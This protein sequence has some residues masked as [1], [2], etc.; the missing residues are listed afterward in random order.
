MKY[1]LPFLFAATLTMSGLISSAV[2]QNPAPTETDNSDG[3]SADVLAPRTKTPASTT[4]TTAKKGPPT[5][6]LA[7]DAKGKTPATTFAPNDKI[8]L[9]WTAPE[10]AKGDKLRAVWIA[11]DTGKA[12]PKNKK[13]IEDNNTVPGPGASGAFVS[14]AVTGGLPAG[15]YL[16]EFYINAKLIKSAKFTVGK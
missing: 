5:A 12:F 4:T 2:G 13:L 15:K 6:S 8:Y 1:F 16:A 10:A 14:P 3:R 9:V 7:K 11:E